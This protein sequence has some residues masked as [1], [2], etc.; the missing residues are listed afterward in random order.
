MKTIECHSVG[1]ITNFNRKI[2]ERGK[3][4]TPNIKIRDCSLS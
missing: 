2:A 3:I 4:G 1:G